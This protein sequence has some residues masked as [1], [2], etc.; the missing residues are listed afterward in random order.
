MRLAVGQ[1]GRSTS[2]LVG[3]VLLTTVLLTS[4]CQPAVEA[5]PTDQLIRPARVVLV[6]HVQPKS[7]HRF[8][9][10]VEAAQSVDLSF[11]VAGT[12]D[13]LPV[14]E[15]QSIAKGTLVAALDP[16]DLNLAVREAQVQ[17]RLARQ[18]LDRKQRM[19]SNR[20]IAQST[21][22][23][24]AATHELWQVRLA[25]ARERLADSRLTAPF[26]AYVARRYL[27]NFVNVRVG[28]T[29][30]RLHDTKEL[31]VVAN[32]PEDLLATVSSDQVL[33]VKASFTFIPGETF[34]LTYRKN[35]GEAD[36]VAQ[37]YEV[38]FAMPRP[39]EWNILPGM[40]AKVDVSLARLETVKAL[41]HI[42][43]AALV[44]QADES[45]YV[46]LYDPKTHQVQRQPVEVGTPNANG[47]P[48]LRGLQG[49][50]MVVTS[51]ASQLQEG[52]QIRVLGNVHGA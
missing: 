22:D 41:A 43:S 39:A 38:A 25:Q 8:V 36:S 47:I 7:Q 16:T 27:D 46:W 18:D 35:R 20:S 44:A 13:K 32:I 29:V 42:P 49:G 37:T 24:A 10:R 33:S 4:G 9:G 12:L 31:L 21:L 3:P 14:D 23:Q 19:L 40:N 30:A 26:D 48:V 2:T 6:N 34:T 52:M 28:D 45:I 1:L 51:G 17:L 50:E 11:E 5:A 15:G